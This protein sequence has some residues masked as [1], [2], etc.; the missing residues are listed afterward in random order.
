M[1]GIARYAD[2]CVAIWSSRTA[3][4]GGKVTGKNEL[5]NCWSGWKGA[6]H[7]FATKTDPQLWSRF[8]FQLISAFLSV[9]LQWSQHFFRAL[10]WPP[11]GFPNGNRWPNATWSCCP[12][13]RPW[14]KRRATHGER[15]DLRLGRVDDGSDLRDIDMAWLFMGKSEPETIDFPMKYWMFLHFFPLNQ[16]IETWM[17][18]NHGEILGKSR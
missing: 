4:P 2:G 5:A 8:C 1:S 15:R 6:D 17:D 13:W 18:E 7:V 14:A 9:L 10:Q 11:G 16:S 3:S 12:Q